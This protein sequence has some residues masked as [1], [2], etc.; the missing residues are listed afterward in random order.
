MAVF[1]KTLWVHIFYNYNL[2][3][4]GKGLSTDYLWINILIVVYYSSRSNYDGV[5]AFGTYTNFRHHENMH[6]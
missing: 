6:L 3:I 1:A 2:T 5:I 4:Q